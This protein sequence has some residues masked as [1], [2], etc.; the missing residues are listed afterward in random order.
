V[1]TRAGDCSQDYR[2]TI[3]VSG[4]HVSSAGDTPMEASGQIN[5]NGMVNLQFRRFGQFVKVTGHAAKG[6]GSG[7]WSSPTM[8]CSG[9]W[10]ATKKGLAAQ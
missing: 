6:T 9:S 4:G 5:S 8:Q 2:W 7:T 1:T 3:M 10:Q